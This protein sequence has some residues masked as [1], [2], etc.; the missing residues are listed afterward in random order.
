MTSGLIKR[1]APA[2]VLGGVALAGVIGVDRFFQVRTPPVA[3]A[4][5]PEQ[6]TE[7]VSVPV[8]AS[9]SVTSPEPM[10]TAP[11][12]VIE[13]ASASTMSAATSA[14]TASEVATA[15]KPVLTTAAPKPL[16]SPEAKPESP[17][18]ESAPVVSGPAVETRWGP[19]QVSG[20][21]ANGEICEVYAVVWPD[22]ESKSVAINATAI[23]KLNARASAD[24]VEFDNV[25]GATFTSDGYRSSLQQLLDSM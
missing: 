6:M 5:T 13:S 19:V 18:C 17:P 16:P 12:A 3:Q 23:P 24:G 22:S 20:T 25:S 10:A 11:T 14:P 9:G 1:I 8:T 21:F 4:P 15:P 2:I 7:P